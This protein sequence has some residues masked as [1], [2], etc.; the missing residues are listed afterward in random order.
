M[1]SD[2]RIERSRLLYERAIRNADAG[3]LTEAGHELDAV[4]A[5]LALARGLVIHGYFLQQRADDPSHPHSDPDELALFERAGQ[6]YRDLGDLR[7]EAEALFWAGCY[8]QVIRRDNHTALPLLQRSL[9]LAGTVGN[10]R[11]MAEALRHLGIAEHA[12]G[13]LDEARA[14]LDESIRLR[15]EG[16]DLVG[17]AANL[18]GLIYIAAAQGRP[19]DALALAAQAA[20][21]A[22]ANGA[23]SI[24]RQ[25]EEAR[26][27]LPH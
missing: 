3:A 17:V 27:T 4:E 12:A 14:R 5:D 16:G 20:A 24:M 9:E 23:H 1:N 13:N 18:V 15:R 26:E 25:V 19:D 8:H 6:L 22:E 7:G 11:T 21:I 10:Q 2:G